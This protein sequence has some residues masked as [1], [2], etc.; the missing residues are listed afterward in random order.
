[1]LYS[2]LKALFMYFVSIPASKIK[3]DVF[4]NMCVCI[5]RL[6]FVCFDLS[7]NPVLFVC[8]FFYCP[9][10]LLL[11]AQSVSLWCVSPSI[12]VSTIHCFVLL[13]MVMMIWIVFFIFYHFFSIT[14]LFSC[15]FACIFVVVFF[16]FNFWMYFVIGI[17]FQ[18]AHMQFIGGTCLFEW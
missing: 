2:L 4:P 18:M 11:S 13:V 16:F 10:C 3:S 5:F 14:F 1:M 15:C 9:L 8:F 6:S 7:E 12:E 17:E